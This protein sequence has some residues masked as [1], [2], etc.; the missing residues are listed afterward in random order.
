M[1]RENPV[2]PDDDTQAD[3]YLAMC[4]LLRRNAWLSTMKYQIR[5]TGFSFP[6]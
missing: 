1:G 2:L 4:R 5:K 6:A 3:T